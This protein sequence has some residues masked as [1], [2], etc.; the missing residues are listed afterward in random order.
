ML[1]IAMRQFRLHRCCSE[2]RAC[3]FYKVANLKLLHGASSPVPDAFSLLVPVS[4]RVP[5]HIK[6]YPRREMK[7]ERGSRPLGTEDS[8][9]NSKNY[10]FRS[11][12]FIDLN[13]S[14]SFSNLE[15]IFNAITRYLELAFMP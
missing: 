8:M 3:S 9:A 11:D 7:R 10:F 6:S 12:G 1:K 14:Y 15:T 13:F 4:A 5:H 2:N